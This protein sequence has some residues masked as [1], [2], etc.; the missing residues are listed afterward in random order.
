MQSRV[1]PSVAHGPQGRTGTPG[2][3]STDDP[4]FDREPPV[5][6]VPKVPTSLEFIPGSLAIALIFGLKLIPE[7]YF[8]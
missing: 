4:A 2:D 6:T 7:H 3:K 8:V 5:G 1:Q